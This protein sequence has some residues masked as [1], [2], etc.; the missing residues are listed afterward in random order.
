MFT[1]K[2]DLI[3][4]L[5]TSSINLYRKVYEFEYEVFKLQIHLTK[6]TTH[7]SIYVYIK[8]PLG[9]NE[10]SMKMKLG[11]INKNS[12]LCLQRSFSSKYNKDERGFGFSDFVDRNK[13][14]N[15]VDK[16][17]NINF[18]LIVEEC[19]IDSN[20]KKQIQGIYE[21]MFG[22]EEHYRIKYEKNLEYLQ[23]NVIR[24]QTLLDNKPVVVEQP[25]EVEIKTIE[26]NPK[27]INIENL[28]ENKLQELQVDIQQL[29]LKITQK[30]TDMKKCQ[31]CMEK[32]SN[33]VLIPCGHKSYCFECIEKCQNKCPCCRSSITNVCKMY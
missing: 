4:L 26:V 9:Y 22:L 14:H 16:N 28:D 7:I 8:L 30:L 19:N 10:I 23:S 18:G 5:D 13:L 24:L 32:M 3:D 15:Y 6:T 27:D 25:V 20:Q 11:I 12:N 31:I 21:K 17:N 2:T 29:Q 1:F 33:C